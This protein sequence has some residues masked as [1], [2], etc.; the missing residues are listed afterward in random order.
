MTAGEWKGL[1]CVWIFTNKMIHRNKRQSLVQASL[2]M[3]FGH[4]PEDTAHV[5]P[6]PV[7]ARRD[8]GR[9][10]CSQLSPQMP[11]CSCWVQLDS[12]G[13]HGRGLVG[14]VEQL[15]HCKTTAWLDLRKVTEELPKPWCEGALR[16]ASKTLVS[17]RG[18]PKPQEQ[19]TSQGCPRDLP[20]R[21]KTLPNNKG[22]NSTA[23]STNSRLD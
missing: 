8:L 18:V 4:Q 15:L 16:G 22:L 11:L 14:H 17:A 6:A 2:G 3:Q 5:R 12:G 20:R 13:P 23:S 9:E 21:P 7:L 19:E 10:P 1:R